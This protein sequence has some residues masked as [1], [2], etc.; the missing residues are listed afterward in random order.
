MQSHR[1]IQSRPKQR[2]RATKQKKNA[3][4]MQWEP[5]HKKRYKKRK[6]NRNL[7]AI[8][9]ENCEVCH[10]QNWVNTFFGF[11]SSFF[12]CRMIFL[13]FDYH[14]NVQCCTCCPFFY[15][16][17]N[18]DFHPSTMA[19]SYWRERKKRNEINQIKS[20]V[21][22][23]LQ[24]REWRRRRMKRKKRRKKRFEPVLR[25]LSK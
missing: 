19:D 17:I 10:F 21:F 18:H 11:F 9:S 14:E 2:I 25:D 7:Y 16:C 1:V 12:F 15:W 13:K 4:L 3:R 20:M 5:L 8:I 23:F 22:F 6:K 24:L